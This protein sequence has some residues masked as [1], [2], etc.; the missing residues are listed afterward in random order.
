MSR[1]SFAATIGQF[2]GPS[3]LAVGALPRPQARAG[4][5]VVEVEAASVNPIDVRRRAGYGRRL[6]SLLG[7]ARLPLV[8]GNDFVGKVAAV[9]RGVSGLREGDAV[10]GAIPPSSRGTHATHVALKAVHAAL[11]PPAIEAA[12]L[13]ALPY[14][15]LT[16]MRAFEGAGITPRNAAGREVLVHGATGG[17]G[18]I[19]VALLQQMGAR[20]TASGGRRSAGPGQ[21]FDQ[22][23]PPLAALAPHFAA[24]LNF[25]SWDDEPALLR[26]LAEDAIGHATTVHPMLGLLDSAG[27]VRGG[28]AALRAKRRMAALAPPGARYAWSVFR[29]D[30]AAL[31]ALAGSAATLLP[32]LVETFRLDQVAEAHRHVERRDPGRAILLPQEHIDLN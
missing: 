23:S 11:R 14:N 18:R 8:L 28:L 20:I 30:P 19:A 3:Q 7:A 5:I 31:S 4:E 24:T 22:R 17:L 21:L 15:Y 27:V 16:V 10:F 12:T 13:A 25:A 6:M 26:L 32:A 9:G 1:S 2:G 29:P